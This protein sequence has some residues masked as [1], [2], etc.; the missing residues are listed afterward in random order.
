MKISSPPP[1]PCRR[2]RRTVVKFLMLGFRDLDV[3]LDSWIAA[4]FTL[5]FSRKRSNSDSLL[6]IPFALNCKM[7]N[8]SSLGL[9]VVVGAGGGCVGG[10]AGG[11]TAGLACPIF[12]P[13][14]LS[15]IF[16][17]RTLR[18][19]PA[20]TAVAQVA[21]SSTRDVARAEGAGILCSRSWIWLHIS[22]GEESSFESGNRGSSQRRR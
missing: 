1:W 17:I 10:G 18:M 4:T 13:F 12:R 21:D 6:P 9:L 15:S 7:L 14:V 22:A 20:R 3:S 16:E 11:G 8:V 5:C 19:H 2:P